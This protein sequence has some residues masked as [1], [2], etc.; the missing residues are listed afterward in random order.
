LITNH[1]IGK[2]GYFVVSFVLSVDILI[3]MQL[4][5][6]MYL[7]WGWGWAMKLKLT[8]SYFYCTLNLDLYK[9]TKIKMHLKFTTMS[10]KFIITISVYNKS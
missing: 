4:F 2:F 10:W 7:G 6:I 1:N 5:L 8:L 9:L 3:W